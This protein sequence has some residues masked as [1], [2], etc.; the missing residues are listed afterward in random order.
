MYLSLTNYIRR[1]KQMKKERKVFTIRIT[2]RKEGRIIDAVVDQVEFL[3][4]TNEHGL[5]EV[6]YRYKNYIQHFLDLGY[7]PW[8]I[9]EVK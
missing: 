3:G 7:E 5:T 4:I 2:N 9:K 8:V 1:Y 6:G